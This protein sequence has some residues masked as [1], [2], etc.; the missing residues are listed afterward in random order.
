VNEDY[1]VSG[2]TQSY[3]WMGRLL[4]GFEHPEDVF[5]AVTTIGTQRVP[6]AQEA[7]ITRYHRGFLDTIAAT[8]D[9]VEVT[10]QIQYR[11]GSGPCLAAIDTDGV[12]RSGDVA[13]DS[14]W[15]EFG[16]EAAETTGIRSMLSFR[17]Y[18]E[19]ADDIVTSLNFYSTELDAFDEWAETVGLLLATHGALAAANAWAREK[20]E[21]WQRAVESNREIG[22]AIGILMHSHKITKEDAMALLR[23]ASQRSNRKLADLAAE[24]SETGQ[25]VLPRKPTEDSTRAKPAR[26]GGQADRSHR[27]GSSTLDKDAAK[28]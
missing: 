11:H 15:P 25:L 4:V 17:L 1:S 16:R 28:A 7:G 9:I 24:V 26:P 14:R 10:D 23:V 5:R 13:G 2:L 8:G 18:V 20:S 21:N 3:A 19:D 27:N 22:V 12:F 6:G